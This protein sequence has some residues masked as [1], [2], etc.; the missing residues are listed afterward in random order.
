MENK[1]R[2]VRVA[3]TITNVDSN[4][5]TTLQISDRAEKWYFKSIHFQRTGGT[6]ATYQLRVSNDTGWSPGD[7]TEFY[8]GTAGVVVA[9]KTYELFMYPILFMTDS[10][11][12]AYLT[13]GF[14]VGSDNDG[15]Y[16]LWFECA[17]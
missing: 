11:G 14:D 13:C 15:V 5:E 2:V 16:E 4:D 9:T 8:T 3:G 1:K 10:S 6:A 7:T 17:E 12:C